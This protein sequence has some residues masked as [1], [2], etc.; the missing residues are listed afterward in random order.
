MR[1]GLLVGALLIFDGTHDA[2]AENS[3]STRPP[4]TGQGDPGGPK[5]RYDHKAPNCG[6]G[7]GAWNDRYLE[8]AGLEVL[9][10]HRRPGQK[11]AFPPANGTSW[12]S[13][14]ACGAPPPVTLKVERCGP[15]D[16]GSASCEVTAQSGKGICP[17]T[18]K[19]GT[20]P[21]KSPVPVVAV[22]GYWDAAGKWQSDDASVTFACNRGTKTEPYLGDGAVATCVDHGFLPDS[23]RDGLLACIRGLRAD[24]CGDGD[25][26]TLSGTPI[27]IHG[28]HPNKSECGYSF[29]ASWSP[30]G[31][32]CIEH[33]R[34][35]F[36]GAP[37][38]D[39]FQVD[40]TTGLLCRT[41]TP[42]PVF[43]TRSNCNKCGTSPG[44][45][46]SKPDRDKYC[47]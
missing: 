34:Y 35:S 4:F 47:H 41:G 2:Q 36:E 46:C 10:F 23:D 32:V 22:R 12:S 33:H 1:I 14:A 5:C 15:D 21:D 11:A 18:A 31:A 30:K 13:T 38:C 45:D 27:A 19:E 24:Y 17:S 42:P 29:E 40:P 25:S 7:F 26:Y 28:D 39:G 37:K 8:G 43:F 9:H 3:S 16:R 6:S 20:K 44:E